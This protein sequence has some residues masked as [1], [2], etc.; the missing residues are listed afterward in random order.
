MCFLREVSRDNGAAHELPCPHL[1]G[2]VLAANAHSWCSSP[3]NLSLPLTL[4]TLHPG[5][6]IIPFLCR[7][8]AQEGSEKR[9][10]P[11]PRHLGAG[12]GGGLSPLWAGITKALSV[13]LSRDKPLTHLQ[14]RYQMSLHTDVEPLWDPQSSWDWDSRARGRKTDFSTSETRQMQIC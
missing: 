14:S 13:G 3:L 10:L 7:G 11:P 2:R 9:T 6:P 12:H 5:E 8:L 4:S 1:P